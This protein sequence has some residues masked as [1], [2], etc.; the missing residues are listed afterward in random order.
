MTLAAHTARLNDILCAAN[1]LIWDAR[2]QMPAG[3]AETRG[4]QIATLKGLARDLILSPAM[5]GAVDAALNA[6]HA[7]PDDH[8]DRRAALSVAAAIT[9]H[10]KIPASLLQAQAEIAT[11]A[12]AAWAEARA[13][14]DFSIFRPLLERTI[15]Q[16]RAQAD[17]LGYDAH[18]YDAMLPT[19]EPGETAASLA[20][21]FDALRAGLKPILA[22]AR[23]KPGPRTDFLYRDFPEDAQ[24]AFAV[25]LAG[26]LGYDATRGR[27]D[28]AVHPFEI[29]FTRQD[30]R[31]TTRYR[32]NYLPMSI[33]GTAHETGH[34]LYEQGIAPAFT[35]SAHATDMIGLYA[36]G[37]TS[38][39]A[40]ESQ[41]RLIEMHIARDPAFWALH[42]DRLARH[43]PDQLRDVTPAEFAAA[44]NRIEPGLVR[45][46]ADE[47]TYDFHIMLRVDLEMAL[48]DGSLS[49][50]DLPEAWN[51]AIARDLGLVVP[52]DAMGCLQDVHWSSGYV[53]SFPTY[54][55]GNIMAAQLM[56]HIRRSAPLVTDAVAAGDYAPLHQRLEEDVWRHGRS[57][58]RAEIVTR[59]TGAAPHV[60]PYLD[61]LTRRFG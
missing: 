26:I 35:R 4:Q 49:V 7:L 51:A 61:H 60:A 20:A 1:L 30:V 18:P 29:S 39:G 10:A 17:A 13:K 44:V 22:A 36:V 37:G 47:L 50:A 16:A 33:F 42:F 57:L 56:D 53:G 46:E 59:A 55:I 24:R 23:D 45:V 48:M 34:A 43:F 28:T 54:T 9:H 25:E 14:S 21:T 38:F 19:Y 2:T 5:R 41:S 8:P 31:I 32:R 6:T 3:G 15:D 58:T 40:H 11:V 12:Q 27:L 52:N